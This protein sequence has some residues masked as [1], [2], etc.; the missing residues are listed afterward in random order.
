MLGDWIIVVEALGHKH[1]KGFSVAEYV[2]PTFDVEIALPSYATRSK[3]DVMAT[4][5][6][7]YTYGKP[8]KGDLTLTVQTK[9]YNP[10]NY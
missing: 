3:S 9:D 8:V 6:A 1:E 2:L 7:V 5:K 10:S 4:I